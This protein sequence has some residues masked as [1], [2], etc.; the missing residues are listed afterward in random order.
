M[1]RL[2]Q[3]GDFIGREFFSNFALFRMSRTVKAAYGICDIMKK[4]IL[5]LVSAVGLLSFTGCISDEPLNAECDILEVEL[6][7][8]I[9]NRNPSISNDKVS[10]VVKNGVSITT[11]AP[12]FVLTPGATIEPE[13][14]TVLDFSRPQHYTVT[15]EDGEWHKTYIVEVQYA[16][17]LNLDYDFEHVKR[18]SALMGSCSYD[19]FYEVGPDGRESMTWGSANAAYALTL[20]GSTPQTFP[21]YQ[22]DDGKTGKCLALTTRSTGSFGSGMGKPIAA[23]NLFIGEFSMGD[24][25]SR[26]LEATHFGAPFLSRPVSLSGSYRYIPG[27]TYTKLGADGTLV[28][29][30]DKVD[31][32][33]IYA[34]FFEVTPDMQWLDGTNVMAADNPNIIAVAEIDE[35]LPAS[36]WTTFDI[37]FVYRPGKTV[38]PEK[39]AAGNYSITVVMC[40]SRDGDF[41]S[42]AVGS[43]LYVDEVH[44]KADSLSE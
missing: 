35:A 11:L 4:L 24:A 20:Q 6:P 39:L 10:I 38:D 27:E 5:G 37:P 44:L 18:V 14:G 40:S 43:T 21:T 19:V 26:P 16:S 30:E 7:S 33:N 29:V 22:Y 3:S 41:F 13:S 12:E 17:T 23:G 34:V 15:S 8:G 25:L 31:Q 1:S 9:L 32:F 42:G 2:G 28:P 36:E